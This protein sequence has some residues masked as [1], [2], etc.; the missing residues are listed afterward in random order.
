M[1]KKRIKDGLLLSFEGIEG[2][3][4]TTQTQLLAE[5]LD[6]EG[7]ACYLTREPGGTDFGDALRLCLLAEYAQP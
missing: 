4:K 2:V 1:Q 5:A 7:Y 6:A 3:G